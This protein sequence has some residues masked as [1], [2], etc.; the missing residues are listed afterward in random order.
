[1][2]LAADKLLLQELYA[3][4]DKLYPDN[5][6]IIE[7]FALSVSEREIATDIGLSQKAINKRKVKVLVRLRERFKDF[8]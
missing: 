5:R 4:L 6:K 1:M 3:A 7:L 8:F 2:D